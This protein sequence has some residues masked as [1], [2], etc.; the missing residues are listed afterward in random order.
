M[1]ASRRVSGEKV[2]DARL[3]AHELSC[4]RRTFAELILGKLVGFCLALLFLTWCAS[5]AFK[6]MG[7]SPQFVVEELLGDADRVSELDG[8]VRKGDVYDVQVRFMAEEDFI[9]ALPHKGFQEMD[10]ADAQ[11]TIGFSLMRLAAWP[12]WRP[13]D[14]T[15]VVCFRRTGENKWSP[16]GRDVIL[17]EAEG[18]WVY[19]AGEGPEH[20]RAM[21]SDL[22]VQN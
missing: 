19:F 4:C 1:R 18:G 16:R 12:P 3:V 8:F 9:L 14:L 7:P 11:T 15:N 5:V 17:A 22:G 6:S 10:C 21:P 20:D 2:Y 13:E